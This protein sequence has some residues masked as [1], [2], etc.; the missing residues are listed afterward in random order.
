MNDRTT[1]LLVLI[2]LTI[3]PFAIASARPRSQ[4]PPPPPPP[5][6]DYSPTI[7]ERYEFDNGRFSLRFPEKPNERVETSPDGK[8]TQHVIEY[9]GLLTYRAS[10][11]DFPGVLE[12]KVKLDD[13]L[14]GMKAAMV[15]ADKSPGSKVVAERYV[16][17]GGHRALFFQIDHGEK[18]TLRI[19]LIAIGSRVYILSTE[20]HRGDPR[21]ME[22]ADNFEK[23]AWGFLGSF[24][25]SEPDATRPN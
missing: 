25:T 12:E 16:D 14:Q 11:V 3:A 2:S 6:R 7:W 1:K 24:K 20:G 17:A 4:G 18:A 5:A 15:Q 23:I 19:E 13:L 21:E 8:T 9:K 10:Y 22:G